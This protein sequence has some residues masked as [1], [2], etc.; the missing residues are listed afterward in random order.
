MYVEFIINCF[1]K[2]LINDEEEGHS[3]I[4]PNYSSA[5]W[6]IAHILIAL[7]T[8]YS[9]FPHLHNW[10]SSVNLVLMKWYTS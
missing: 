7:L 5:F 8:N 4:L 3:S 10:E 9:Y 6:S 2:A 1:Q